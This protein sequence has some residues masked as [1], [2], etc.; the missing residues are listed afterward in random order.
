MKY[1][2]SELETIASNENTKLPLQRD[3]DKFLRYNN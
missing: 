2:N 3:V 1:L